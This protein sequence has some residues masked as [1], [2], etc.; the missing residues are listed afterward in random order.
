MVKKKRYFS[1]RVPFSQSIFHPRANYPPLKGECKQRINPHS[2]PIT[3]TTTTQSKI[4]L[5]EQTENALFIPPAA[6]AC[7]SF[8]VYP[9]V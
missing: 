4:F 1:A 5:M 6:Q 2:Y 7:V 3:D 9:C 8:R